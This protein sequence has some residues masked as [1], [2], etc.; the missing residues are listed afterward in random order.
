MDAELK[1]TVEEREL[2]ERLGPL[3]EEKRLQMAR[4]LAS[5]ADSELFGQNEFAV[6]DQVH[7]LGAQALEAAA[8]ERQKKGRIRGS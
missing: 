6:R 3:F 7:Q 5:K 8:N 1:L 4:A 2:Y